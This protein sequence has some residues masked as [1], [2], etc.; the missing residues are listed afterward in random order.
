MTLVKKE[1]YH[2]K[3]I[4]LFVTTPLNL[5]IKEEK[6]TGEKL[7]KRIKTICKEFNIASYFE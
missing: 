2:L 1:V 6:L 5:L 7:Q 3:K 4:K